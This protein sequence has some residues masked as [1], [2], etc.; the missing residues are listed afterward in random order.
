MEGRLSCNNQRC[1]CKAVPSH[2]LSLSGSLG[3]SG[4]TR[5]GGEHLQAACDILSSKYD[6]E[7]PEVSAIWSMTSRVR[8]YHPHL[9][10]L[11][12]GGKCVMPIFSFSSQSPSN[13]CDIL[14]LIYSLV[15]VRMAHSRLVLPPHGESSIHEQRGVRLNVWPLCFAPRQ[16]PYSKRVPAHNLAYHRDRQSA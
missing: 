9:G 15:S 13:I 16:G 14:L 6:W 3:C 10:H 2:S 1:Q 4:V 11:V 5:C 8:S 12:S 7:P